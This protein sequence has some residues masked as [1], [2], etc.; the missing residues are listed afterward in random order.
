MSH[1]W[2]EIRKEQAI[3]YLKTCE[4]AKKINRCDIEH[5]YWWK[6]NKEW[7]KKA[8]EGMKIEDLPESCCTDELK[9]DLLK[10][11]VYKKYVIKAT[12]E[13]LDEIVEIDV[14]GKTEE[15]IE[16]ELFEFIEEK[17]SYEFYKATK[18][19][20]KNYGWKNK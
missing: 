17:L 19:D 16:E 15:E 2:E 20:L 12:L 3:Q 7:I 13:D 10:N 5:C 8:L 1:T 4:K 14:D 18:K 11:A 9:A 6:E